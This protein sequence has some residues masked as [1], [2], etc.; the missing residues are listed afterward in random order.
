[1][2]RPWIIFF[3]CVLAGIA[4][5]MFYTLREAPVMKDAPERIPTRNEVVPPGTSVQQIVHTSDE[6]RIPELMRPTLAVKTATQKL[7]EISCNPGTDYCKLQAIH[8]FVRLNYEH[9]E[10]SPE[11]TYIQSPSETIIYGSGDN[12]ELA[13]LI[14]SM[15]RSAGFENEILL[16]PY[17]TFVRVKALNQTFTIDPSCQAC[18]FT[19]VRVSANGHERVFK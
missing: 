15:Q 7:L 14:A 10:N 1:M 19:D 4:L 5:I 12:L 18:K 17:H 16:G 8:D 11:H 6:L 2:A 9:R 3:V 13:L